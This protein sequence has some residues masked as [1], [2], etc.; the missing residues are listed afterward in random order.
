QTSKLVYM[1]TIA[2]LDILNT[3]IMILLTSILIS[4]LLL[5]IILTSDETTSTFVKALDMLNRKNS[6]I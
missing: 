4:S 3:L 2:G 6:I 5:A 1:N